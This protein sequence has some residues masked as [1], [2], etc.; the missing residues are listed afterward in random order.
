MKTAFRVRDSSGRLRQL[1]LE[2]ALA[3]ASR[4]LADGEHANAL[5]IL[6]KAVR[7]APFNAEARHLLGHAQANT[8]SLEEA[9]Y[10]LRKAADADPN[11]AAYRASLAHV[12]MP[13]YPSEAVPHFL[14]A[15]V[16]GSSNPHVFGNLASILLDLRREEDALKVCEL[17]LPACGE[18]F[19][20]LGS[21]SLALL[22][23]GR[24][25]EALA[26]CRRQ[27]ELRPDDVKALCNMGNILGELGR[28]AESEEVLTHACLL[29]P[30]NG[31]AHCNL[32]QTLLLGGQYRQGFREY[33]WRWSTVMRDQR[34]N[35][36][37]PL[38]DGSFLEGKHI[39]LHAEQGAGDTIQFARY[40]PL[41]AK[42]GGRIA[43]EVPPSLERLLTWLQVEQEV[44][45]AALPDG[46]FV[47]HCPLL[48]LPLIFGTELE[49]IPPPACFTIPAAIRECWAQRLAGGRPKVGLV[50]AGRPEHTNDRYRSLPL[51]AFLPLTNV[52]DV[53]FF[54]LQVGSPAQELRSEGLAHRIR[55]LSPFLTDFA[56]TAAALSCMDLLISADTA[57]AH[58]AGTLGKPVWMLTPFAPD[59]RWLLNRNDSPWYPSMRLFRQKTPGGWEPVIGRILA[60]LPTAFRTGANTGVPQCGCPF[61]FSL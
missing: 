42:L 28:L 8:G 34:R 44:T 30:H 23:L 46:G 45:P 13:A 2:E 20:I 18:Q 57:V 32:A 38:W 50:W 1:S 60:A 54:S 47:T 4:N 61:P 41:V 14:A 25:D 10:N 5:V 7:F 53:E 31:V 27:R 6:D 56:E 33:E 12:L 39:L 40:L 48:S 55:D 59:W 15:I 35:F 37:Q 29:D 58:L 51:R 49:S 19:D 36:I 3:E 21:R 43:L 16:L 52:N 24:H 11:S 9:A 17:S 22:R 26:C